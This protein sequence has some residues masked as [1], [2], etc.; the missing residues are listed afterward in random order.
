[1]PENAWHAE[2]IFLQVRSVAI[3]KLTLKWQLKQLKEK[4][5]LCLIGADRG[6]HWEIVAESKT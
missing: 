4:G 5:I 3:D 6:G 2:R 1:M